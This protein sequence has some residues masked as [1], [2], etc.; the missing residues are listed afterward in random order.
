MTREHEVHENQEVTITYE[1]EDLLW[2]GD[3]EVNA[4]YDPGDRWTPSYSEVE[5]TVLKTESL[6]RYNEDTDDWEDVEVT[7][8]ILISIERE[9]IRGL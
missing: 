6:Q 9:F 3:V 7:T 5:V 2:I 4:S 8:D 1:G